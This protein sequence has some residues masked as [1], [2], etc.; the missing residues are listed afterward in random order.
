MS[1]APESPVVA[2]RLVPWGAIAG[3]GFASGLNLYATVFFLGIAGR[4]FDFVSLVRSQT[5]QCQ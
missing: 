3:S 4:F 2:S 1:G 5:M